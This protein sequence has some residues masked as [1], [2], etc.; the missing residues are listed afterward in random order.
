MMPSILGESLDL[1]E[2]VIDDVYA[3]AP[4]RLSLALNHDWYGVVRNV[5][6]ID[7]SHGDAVFFCRYGVIIIAR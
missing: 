2:G 7:R 5:A 1:G 3:Q 6:R 4:T